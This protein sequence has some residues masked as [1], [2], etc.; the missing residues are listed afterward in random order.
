M[1]GAHV[2]QELQQGEK[3]S[4]I[5]VSVQLLCGPSKGNA[6]SS[7]VQYSLGPRLQNRSVALYIS[8][9]LLVKLD[10]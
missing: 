2:S 8:G 4:W 5:L 9:F 10:W 6:L 7:K 3:I 1:P